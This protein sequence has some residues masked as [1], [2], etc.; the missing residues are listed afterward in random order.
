V[1][2][3]GVGAVIGTIAGSEL[4]ERRRYRYGRRYR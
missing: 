1:V 2:A 3:T 4:A